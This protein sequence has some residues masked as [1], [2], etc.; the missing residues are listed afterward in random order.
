MNAPTSGTT[1]SVT[2]N[3]E[4]KAV[5]GNSVVRYISKKIQLTN[6][7]D[8]GDLRVY[9]DA[10]RPPGSGIAVWYKLLSGSDPSQFDNNNYTLMTQIG[11]TINYFAKNLS[12]YAELTFAPGT[13]GSS[14]ADNKISY[15][16]ASNTTHKDFA[17]F[18]IKVVMYGTSTVDV[19][20]IS[21]L[22]AIALP[23]SSD[24]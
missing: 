20:K 4:D 5:G 3:G 17:T 24:T 15:T 8:A 6:G 9:M 13:Y 2:Y 18:A 14:T 7:F 10:Y 23:A 11:D 19:P 12:D 16:S 21:N 1:A 22:R